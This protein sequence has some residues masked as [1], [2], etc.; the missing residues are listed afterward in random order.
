M[1][2]EKYNLNVFVS[3]LVVTSSEILVY[4]IAYCWLNKMKRKLFAKILYAVAIVCSVLLYFI[5]G[6]SNEDGFWKVI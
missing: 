4:P 3:A 5:G 6:D 1:L 2:L